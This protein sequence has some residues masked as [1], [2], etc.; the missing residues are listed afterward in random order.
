LGERPH[1]TLSF[2]ATTPPQATQA[3]GIYKSGPVLR[4]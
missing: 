3:L 4:D 2:G 1:P